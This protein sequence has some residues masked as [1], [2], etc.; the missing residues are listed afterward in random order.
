MLQGG[1]GTVLFLTATMRTNWWYQYCCMCRS[2][3]SAFGTG[4]LRLENNRYMYQYGSAVTSYTQAVWSMSSAR[5][6]CHMRLVA[7]RLVAKLSPKLSSV[8]AK[9][10]KMQGIDQIFLSPLSHMWCWSTRRHFVGR[11]L[12]GIQILF[13]F[14]HDIWC[15]RWSSVFS[16]CH[17][18]ENVASLS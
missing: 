9:N 10:H 6:C 14:L 16:G 2:K 11:D 4:L 17:G 13:S 7:R 3:A 12:V 18:F 15:G 5:R 1:F 8:S